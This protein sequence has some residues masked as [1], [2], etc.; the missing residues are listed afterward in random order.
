MVF[1][2]IAA[3]FF[4]ML[5]SVSVSVAAEK[6]PSNLSK[7]KFVEA[8]IEHIDYDNVYGT[9][10]VKNSSDVSITVILTNF[11]KE[12]DRSELIFHSELEGALPLGISVDGSSR[13]YSSPFPLD[14]QTVKEVKIILSGKA[15]AEVKVRKPIVFLAIEQE[16]KEEKYSVIEIKKDVTAEIIEN[17]LRAWHKAEGEIKEANAA[18]VNATSAGL[19]VDE[20]NTSFELA[21]KLLNESLSSYS[22]GKPGKALEDAEE[23]SNRAI[24]AKNKAETAIKS[25]EF[26]NYGVMGAIVVVVAVVVLL[27]YVRWRRERGRV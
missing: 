5:I 2:V 8:K 10:M 12:V 18:I 19:E 25:V 23:S 16:T 6:E 20:A 13:E 1:L 21:K 27:L 15:P 7:S 9:E 11:S 22:D 24:E 4:L 3:L 17:A 26:R 14:H